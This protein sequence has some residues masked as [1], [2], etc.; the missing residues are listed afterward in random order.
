MATEAVL[1]VRDVETLGAFY[2]QCVGL[3]PVESDRNYC[4]L[5]ADDLVLWLVRARQAPAGDTDRGSPRPRSEVP[6]KLA[7]EVTSIEGVA[8]T[9]EACGGSVAPATWEFAGYHR[10]DATDPEG[11]VIQLLEPSE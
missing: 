3:T 5:Q 4:K 2:R 1:Y 7:F 11:N 9:I 8:G 6:V 10:R